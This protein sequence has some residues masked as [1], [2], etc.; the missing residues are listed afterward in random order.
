MRKLDFDNK[1]SFQLLDMRNL[2]Q[3]LILENYTIE[4]IENLMGLSKHQINV[5]LKYKYDESP[6]N[7][8]PKVN[9]LTEEEMI[10]G[11]TNYT[12]DDLAPAEKAIFNN[13]K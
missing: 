8:V 6:M 3:R 1:S 13:L 2:I 11:V 7:T 12:Y 9:D 5:I 10:M 4:R